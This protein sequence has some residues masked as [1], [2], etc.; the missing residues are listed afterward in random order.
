MSENS[1][2]VESGG[3]LATLADLAEKLRVAQQGIAKLEA[4]LKAA[5]AVEVELRDKAIPD[6]MDELGMAEFE[7]RSGFKIKIV[8]NVFASISKDRKT[9]AH[10]WLD[11]NGHGGMIRRKVLVEFNREQGDDAKKLATDLRGKYPAVAQELSVHGTTLK[12]WAKRML[13]EGEDIPLDLFGIHT[14]KTAK[15]GK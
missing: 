1:Y 9:R 14:Q 2:E 12:S 6:L 13:T 11:E 5:Q 15:I 3:D 4:E 7:T 8:E 10:A